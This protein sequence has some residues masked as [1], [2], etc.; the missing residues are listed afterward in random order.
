[1][2]CEEVQRQIELY[3]LGDAVVDS[4][5]I[6]AHLTR[7]LACRTIEGEYRHIVDSL[8]QSTSSNRS[9]VDFER[10]VLHA[11][12]GE[13]GEMGP[14]PRRPHR[15]GKISAVA[16]CLL[17][18]LGLWQIGFR[19]EGSGKDKGDNLQAGLATYAI[20]A[21]AMAV[22]TSGADNILV[23]GRDIYL[24]REIGSRTNL[25]AL[26]VET[27]TQ[28]WDSNVDSYGYLALGD[29]QLCCLAPNQSGGLDLVAIGAA[30]G[31][32]LWRH[33]QNRPRMFY[34]LCA[35]MFLPGDRICW[36]VGNT[37]RILR[38]RDGKLLW[39]QNIPGEQLLC[40]AL[41][42]DQNLYV[43]GS[44]GLYQLGINSGEHIWH[45]KYEFAISR[46]VR[47]LLVVAGDQLC[48]ALRERR[49]QSV[50]MCLNM[51]NKETLWTQTL[52]PISHLCAAQERLYLRSQS[53][54]ALDL[55]SGDLL[56]N[57]PSAGCSPIT[58][59]DGRVWFVDARDNGTLVALD[60]GSGDKVS[61]LAGLRSCN[62]LIELNDRAFVKTHDGIV[63]VIHLGG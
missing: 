39:T 14:R 56:W 21:G 7:C 11:V 8:S 25:V 30:N 33:T 3:V 29:K 23:K 15:W 34:G 55:A 51:K 13:I 53:V 54:Q 47:P 50:L 43:A 6:Q 37:V 10:E 32:L 40:T 60:A 31:Q 12:T 44:K 61:A 19:G 16:A 35:P 4:D 24:L 28:V 17:I 36:T 5:E 45:S 27:G 63:H 42:Q 38:S 2:N 22:P 20:P 46:W 62:A 49:G 9:H 48:V 58:F 1:M 18:V 26:N 52:P 57:V 59:A 41:A